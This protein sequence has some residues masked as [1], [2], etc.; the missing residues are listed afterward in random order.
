MKSKDV[1][2]ETI[3]EIAQHIIITHTED[4]EYL[5][6]A[7]MTDAALDLQFDQDYQVPTEED[8]KEQ[9]KI[10]RRVDDMI[11]RAEVTIA[12]PEDC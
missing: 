10:W 2:D 9:E 5:S 8:R 4:I 11:A 3:K 6:V 12:F 1:S 7:E